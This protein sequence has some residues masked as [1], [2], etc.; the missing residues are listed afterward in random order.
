[1]A[2]ITG[3]MTPAKKPAN[4]LAKRSVKKLGAKAQNK[5]ETINKVVKKTRNFFRSILSAMSEYITPEI[6]ALKL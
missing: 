1:M 2:Y 5:V 4:D 6:A 3:V